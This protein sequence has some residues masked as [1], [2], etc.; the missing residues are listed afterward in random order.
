MWAPIPTYPP[1]GYPGNFG[2]YPAHAY[3]GNTYPPVGYSGSAHGYSG[4]AY[5]A[6]AY[7]PSAYSVNAAAHAYS[8]NASASAYPAN[9][10]ASAY[11]GNTPSAYSANTYPAC[12]Y[13]ANS[14]PMHAYP[15]NA[16]PGSIY[17]GSMHAGGLHA[18][19][20]PAASAHAE[21]ATVGYSD[22]SFVN[23]AP[24]ADSCDNSSSAVPSY[25]DIDIDGMTKEQ[26]VT[27]IKE[28][29]KCDSSAKE[30]WIAY[31]DV[32]GQ[33][34]RDP[35]KHDR[36]F[37]EGFLRQ[38][39]S[40]Q[41]LVP[42]EDSKPLLTEVIKVMQRKSSNFKILW[43]AYCQQ[44]GG[45]LND[46]TRHDGTHLL[47]FF[48][49]LSQ[50]A[51][52]SD[53]T[54]VLGSSSTAPGADENPLKRLRDSSGGSMS[55]GMDAAKEALVVSI[56]A[57]Q[58]LGPEQKE[59]WNSY[60][61]NFLGGTRDPARHSISALQ[62][63]CNQHAVPHVSPSGCGGCSPTFDCGVGDGSNSNMYSAVAPMGNGMA[64]SIVQPADSVKDALV[65]RIKDF[66]KAVPD[67]REMWYAFCG[68]TRDPARHS[69]EKLLEFVT[70]F[71]VP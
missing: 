65:Q 9:A 13:S 52:H 47:K 35:N 15:A 17:P 22:S 51:S 43:S 63:F 32:S 31:T 61:D 34:T 40:G 25:A 5:P 36:D 38:M 8:A 60:A 58:R 42:N 20:V 62:E 14:Y 39:Q 30:Q 45:G 67:S 50:S 64:G 69:T 18:G 59:A 54:A 71:N 66:Q 49:F 46:P 4:N 53:T 41:R 2:G 10:S 48:E 28:M 19:N 37:L 16:Y 12:A 1:G 7:P 70:S 68:S 24:P 11:F 6:H 21:P 56:K 55:M 26:I 57:H 3:P 29:Q 27:Q 33:G 23:P 44:N